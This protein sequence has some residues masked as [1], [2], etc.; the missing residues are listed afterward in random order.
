M[1]SLALPFSLKAGTVGVLEIKLNLMSRMFSKGSANAMQISLDNA[2]FIIGPSM[3]VQSRD[4]SYLQEN[5][6]EMLYPY[7]DNNAFNIFQNNLKLRKKPRNT[8]QEASKS[9]ES[10]KESS[11]PGMSDE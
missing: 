4:E 8:D 6:Q 7:D 1:Q 9:A 5:E 11:K 2:F 3:R 10:N